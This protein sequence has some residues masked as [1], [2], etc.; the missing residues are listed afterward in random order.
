VRIF[1][2]QVEAPF[3]QIARY[4]LSRTPLWSRGPRGR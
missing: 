4:G 3:H 2:W 1:E